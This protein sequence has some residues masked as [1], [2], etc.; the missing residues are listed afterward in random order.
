MQQSL[1]QVGREGLAQEKLREDAEAG[2]RDKRRHHRITIIHAELA[3]GPHAGGPTAF[4]EA[5]DFGRH[6]VDVPDAAVLSEVKRVV[7]SP[8]LVEISRRADQVARHFTQPVCT[9]N[10]IRIYRLTESAKLAR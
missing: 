8:M 9:E 7:R 4:G 1:E 5:P 3:R 2:A 10:L 6:G